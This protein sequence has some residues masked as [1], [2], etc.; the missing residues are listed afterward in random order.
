MQAGLLQACQGDHAL[1]ERITPFA[2][3]LRLDL[4]D[5][6]LVFLPGDV[7]VTETG[8]RRDSGTAYTTKE[9]ADEVVEHALAP[10]C[11]SPGPQ[12]TADTTQWRIPT[13]SPKSSTSRCATQR[14]GPGAILVAACRYL[15]ERLIEAWR[16]QGDPR[17]V[18]TATAADDPNRLDVVIEARRMVA[19]RC[20]YGV[21]RNPMATEMAKL[22]MWLTTVAKDRPF[23]FLD[24]AIKSGDSLLG[25]PQPAPT[26]L[27]PLRPRRPAR[28]RPTPI[29]GFH[30]GGEA[31][32]KVQRLIDQAIE[33]RHAVH[34]H[35][36]H[37]PERH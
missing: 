21:D 24:H 14:S 22:S 7:Y 18:E 15:G 5:R 30:S 37:R 10:L 27:P 12:D 25:H 35:R 1:A 3:L 16:A 23:T 17:A 8:S 36:D 32:E 2:R 28:H 31:T 11:Y 19:E 4:R 33:L 9:L 13:A 34:K 6:P 29:S 26:A 20:C